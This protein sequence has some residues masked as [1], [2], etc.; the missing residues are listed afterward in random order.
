MELEFKSVGFLGEEKTRMPRERPL[1]ART[2]TNNK[3]N[4]H[5]TESVNQT[6]ASLV[7]GE[8][9]HHWAIQ[10]P[11][12]GRND[13]WSF[14]ET[15]Q[16]IE[17]AKRDKHLLVWHSGPYHIHECNMY[18]LCTLSKTLVCCRVDGHHFDIRDTNLSNA[19]CCLKVV[20][21]PST[22]C[23]CVLPLYLY[24]EPLLSILGPDL[25]IGLPTFCLE[26]NRPNTEIPF[27]L[28]TYM[29]MTTANYYITTPGQSMG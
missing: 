9:S 23:F 4:K 22:I 27:N 29:Q 3:L 6:W 13:W 28:Q 5:V 8:C 11:F 17:G 2:R 26:I 19:G 7:G 16:G 1:G 21:H 24:E 20:R 12:L 14:L 18:I 10:T 15:W 25:A